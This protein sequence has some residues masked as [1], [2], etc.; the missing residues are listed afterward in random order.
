MPYQ[1]LD[2]PL[3][4][5]FDAVRKHLRIHGCALGHD[6]EVVTRPEL[7]HPGDPRFEQTT[8]LLE[9]RFVKPDLTDVLAQEAIGVVVEEKPA[10]LTGYDFVV[11]DEAEQAAVA[12]DRL[13]VSCNAT[14]YPGPSAGRCLPHPSLPG[15][16]CASHE[17]VQGF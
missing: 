5:R 8:P 3:A 12:P 1:L 11:L 17:L 2:C 14:V 10:V 6:E 13:P 9:L 4:C 7:A 16:R 15:A